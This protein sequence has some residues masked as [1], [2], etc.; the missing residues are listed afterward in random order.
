MKDTRLPDIYIDADGCPVKE[1]I[2]RASAKY[3]LAVYVA[4]NTPMKVPREERI[5]LIIV[6]RGQDAADDWIAE[7]AGAGDVVVTT[8]IPLADRC[9][10]KGARV[11]DVRGREF[12]DDSIGTAMATRDLMQHLRLMGEMSGGPPP[13]AKKD[14]SKFLAKFHEVLQALIRR[15]GA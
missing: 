2:Y 9:L 4:C 10:K 8:D 14:R 13:V 1:E 11:R 7:H 15:A 3:G 12:T 5:R 6:G